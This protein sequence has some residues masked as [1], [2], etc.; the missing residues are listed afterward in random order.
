M[1]LTRLFPMSLM[2]LAA[3]AV[4]A[5]CSSLPADNALLDEARRDYRAAQDNPPTRD[6]AANELKQ[7]GEAL[8]MASDAWTRRD[9]TAQ[10]N[11]LAYVA[12]QRI[13]IAQET[14]RQKAAEL[15]VVNANAA[16]DKIR[17]AAR[18]S[19]AD[20]AVRNAETAQRSAES[21]QM[22]SEASKRQSDAAMQQANLS[23]QQANDAQARNRD[24]E[25]QLKDLNAKQTD[26]GMVI[27]IGDVLFDTNQSQ[28]KSGAM[29][30]VEKLVGF[31]KQY[32]Q[33][34]AVVEGFTDS[35]GSEG[36]NQN[37]SG[38]RADAVRTALLDMGVGGDRVSA[39]GYG[40][41]HPVAGNDTAGGRQLNRRVE[42]VLSDDSGNV[43][44][45]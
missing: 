24:L 21:A 5:G 23:Q 9:N 39:R 1:N 28:L 4:V 7:A 18:T 3:L 25:A 10:I 36:A 35:V 38:R 17:L 13:V 42:I 6:L 14:G 30:N 8:N 12:K 44:P 34:K 11:H 31:L 20:T 22:Q 43:T 33:R 15:A 16:R 27:T 32:P 19:E 26:R 40:E 37:L 41:G 29:R 2:S 45:R